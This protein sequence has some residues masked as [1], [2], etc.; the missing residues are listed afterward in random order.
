MVLGIEITWISKSEVKYQVSYN[1][2]KEIKKQLCKV[3]ALS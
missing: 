2:S 3:A 1:F